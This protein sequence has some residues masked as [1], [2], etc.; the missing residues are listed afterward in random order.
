MMSLEKENG[1][2]HWFIVGG[3][4]SMIAV[5]MQQ[6]KGEKIL[7]SNH[8]SMELKGCSG[9]ASEPFCQINEI[10]LSAEKMYIMWNR[11]K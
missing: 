5:D 3:S 9:R 2:L 11:L 8:V 4:F 6:R 7:E 1:N 10:Q